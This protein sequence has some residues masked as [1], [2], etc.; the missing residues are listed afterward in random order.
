MEIFLRQW[1]RLAPVVGALVERPRLH[2]LRYI[3]IDALDR[4]ESG[5]SGPAK[6]ADLRRSRF[7]ATLKP[8]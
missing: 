5:L 7:G 4:S 1:E 6:P 3:P 8:R 2:A